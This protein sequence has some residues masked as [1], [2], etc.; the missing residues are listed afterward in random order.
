MTADLSLLDWL[1]VDHGDPFIRHHPLNNGRIA[2]WLALPLWMGGR[3]WYDLMGLN[4]GVLTGFNTINNWR[5][6]TRPGGFGNFYGNGTNN[7]YVNIPGAAFPA[8]CRSFSC[9]IRSDVVQSGGA[10]NDILYLFN[11]GSLKWG[12]VNHRATSS[13]ILYNPSF[14]IIVSGAITQGAWYHVVVTT[15]GATANIY[16]NGLLAGTASSTLTLAGPATIGYLGNY[17]NGLEP[18]NGALDDV[19]TW[20]RTLSA[21]DAWNLYDLSRRGYPGMLNRISPFATG[22]S[23]TVFADCRMPSEYLGTLR[24]D[25]AQ[26]AEYLG[27]LQRDNVSPVEWT[28]IVSSVR[29]DS[30]QPIEWLTTPQSPAGRILKPAAQNRI[31]TPSNQNRIL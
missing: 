4:H 12:I 6:T 23:L 20:S 27:S 15:D 18:W 14:A 28:Q 8:T 21:M 24:R 2:W 9:W 16:I 17:T 22:T 31:I 13:V 11:G 5:A 10:D 29:A 3:T 1:P 7:D 19:S 26:P 30:R 25:G